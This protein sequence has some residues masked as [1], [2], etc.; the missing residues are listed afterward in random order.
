MNVKI[1]SRMNG[2][3][4]LLSA[5]TILADGTISPCIFIKLYL[6]NAVY[7]VLGTV[8]LILFIISFFHHFG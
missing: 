3:E 5:F 6:H 7:Y 8:L 4:F 2:A 1:I